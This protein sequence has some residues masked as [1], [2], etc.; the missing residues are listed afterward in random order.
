M[1]Y[2]DIL[3]LFLLPIYLFIPFFLALRYRYRFLTDSNDRFFFR[4]GIIIKIFGSLSALAIYLFYY[5]GGDT[6]EYFTSVEAVFNYLWKRP[7]N[8]YEFL[9]QSDLS[10]IMDT[11]FWTTKSAHRYIIS[12][13]TYTVVKLGMLF[14]TFAFGSILATYILTAYFSFFCSWKF[15][16]LFTEFYPQIKKSIGFAIFF[17][18]SVVF[19]GSGLFKDTFTLGGLYLFIY[20]VVQLLILR[21]FKWSF[22]FYFLFSFYLLL[23]IRSFFIITIFPFLFAWVFF[24][25]FQKIKN[26]NF[27]IIF[28]PL[29]TVII[30]V[31]G[32]IAFQILNQYMLEVN[33]DKIESSLQGFQSWHASLGGSAYSL[34]DFDFTL[35]GYIQK[36]PASINVTY[37]RP[38]IWEVNKPIIFLT[39][40]QSFYFIIF[41]LYVLIK[42]NVGK[43]F[44]LFFTSLD[45]FTL[46][47]FSLFFA[48]V[49]GISS[50]NFGALDRYKIPCLSTYF[51]ALLII[52]HKSKKLKSNE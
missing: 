13:A 26:N 47:G 38:Y 34:G 2:L 15:Y 8:I 16:K 52:L 5:K 40:L 21:K 49:A 32:V 50:Y 10:K 12:K 33:I 44:K 23:N 7:D 3:D 51:I 48:Y 6:V 46:L 24:S 36:I 11:D 19:W 20:S 27:K 29:F 25:Y 45:V 1:K 39:F 30:I 41:T 9:G 35:A 18:P 28:F 43:F 22:V 4:N 37:F 42:V 31:F 17:M 14:Y